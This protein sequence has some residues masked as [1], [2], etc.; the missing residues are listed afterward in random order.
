MDLASHYLET[1]RKELGRLKRQGERALA[2][3]E[4]ARL[5]ETLDPEAN[6]VATLVR[7]LSGNM[8]SRWTDF[9]SSDG[10]KPDRRRDQEFEEQPGLG[11]SELMQAWEQGWQR[12]FAAL[13]GLTASDLLRTV[14]IRGEAHTVVEA[15]ERQLTHY[16][17]HLGQIVLLAKHLAG[18][19]WQ[20]L[21]IPRG[22]SQGVWPYKA[23]G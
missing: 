13:D 9:L 6:S 17:C 12:L 3:V 11:R 4:D 1:V 2:Q 8:L 22:Q 20:T 10:E 23:R 21:S 16:A 18:E 7:H 15:I 5:R 19:R 14:S